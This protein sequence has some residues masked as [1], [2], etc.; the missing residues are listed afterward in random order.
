MHCDLVIGALLVCVGATAVGQEVDPSP[1]KPLPQ[2]FGNPYTSRPLESMNGMFRPFVVEDIIA[3][4]LTSAG[5]VRVLEFGMG[6]ARV[7]MQLRK[8]FPTVELH[9]INEEPFTADDDNENWVRASSVY[10]GIFTQRE[11]RTVE[12]P[13]L[14]FADVDDGRLS[15]LADSTFDLIISQVSVGYIERKDI[16]IEEFWRVLKPGGVALFDVDNFVLMRTGNAMSLEVLAGELREEGYEIEVRRNEFP[17]VHMR[18]NTT[19]PL[20]LRLRPFVPSFPL[21][22]DQRENA[23]K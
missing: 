7:L 22:E 15:F 10:H 18:K 16:L 9:G 23:T 2:Q 11:A 17:F 14:H 21:F 12:L 13:I 3:E 8:R 20:Q 6:E 5:S 19:R 4:K 1:S